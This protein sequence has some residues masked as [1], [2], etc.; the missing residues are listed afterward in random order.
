V[1]HWDLSPGLN[2]GRVSRAGGSIEQRAFLKKV[3]LTVT[4]LQLVAVFLP[5]RGSQ[6]RNRSSA[7]FEEVR[8]RSEFARQIKVT[9]P[10]TD[11]ARALAAA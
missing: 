5:K 11:V 2:I 6:N 7:S 8:A 9:R 1:V 4:D 10:S 3:S